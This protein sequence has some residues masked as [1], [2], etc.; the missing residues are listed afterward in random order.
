[1][2]PFFHLFALRR[3]ELYL[4]QGPS[5]TMDLRFP[6]QWFQLE[7]GLAYN[8]HRHYDPTIGRYIEPDP[9]GL[10]ALLSDGPSVYAYV[11]SSPM[12]S[13]DPF[14]LASCTYSISTRILMCIP[15]KGGDPASLGPNGVWSGV[16]QCAN[17]L[18]CVNI[19]YI[20]PI[21]PGHYDM[22]ADYRPYHEGFW[23]LEPD[24]K[25]SGWKCYANKYSFGIIRKRCGFELH[26]GAR[27]AGCIT[28]DKDNPEAMKQYENL[29][30]LLV[31]DNGN[32]KL[33]VTQ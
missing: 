27:S 24:P 10:Q 18:K 5:A 22:N 14:G 31:H 1:M 32:N 23:R 25:I 29:N 15:N 4:E 3:D 12:S 11:N 2:R 13:V 26:P 21:V 30:D 20:G 33:L 16:N 7:N 19:P 28:T 8:W 17:N 9:L 6:G